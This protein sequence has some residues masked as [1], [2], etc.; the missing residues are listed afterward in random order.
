MAYGQLGSG[1]VYSLLIHTYLQWARLIH[2][3]FSFC[4]LS[5]VSLPL[6]VQCNADCKRHRLVVC[7]D[8]NHN[9]SI[10]NCPL[11]IRPG[12]TATCCNFRWRNLWSP[13]SLATLGVRSK[14]NFCGTY[15]FLFCSV[16][17]IA[18][19]E[20][21]HVNVFACDCIRVTQTKNNP[22]KRANKLTRRIVI[23]GSSHRLCRKQKCVEDNAF[24]QSGKFRLGQE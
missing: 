3:Y 12:S 6:C 11:N 7:Q 17:W 14:W 13:V 4:I 22:G 20:R 16:R 2:F 1:I 10:S 18:A 21:G 24:N 15:H 9:S 23:P 19:L 5:Y 8:D